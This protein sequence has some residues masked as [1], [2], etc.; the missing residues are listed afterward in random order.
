MTSF[1]PYREALGLK[2]AQQE[3]SS[4]AGIRYEPKIVKVALGLIEEN[5]GREFWGESNPKC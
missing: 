4:G 3:L 1:R 5:R 2:L